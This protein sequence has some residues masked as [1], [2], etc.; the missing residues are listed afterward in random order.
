MLPNRREGVLKESGLRLRQGLHLWEDLRFGFRQLVRNPG[1]STVLVLTLAVGVGVNAAILSA[2]YAVV[3]QALPFK[4]PSS[5]VALFRNSPS[6]PPGFRFWGISTSDANVIRARSRTLSQIVIYDEEYKIASSD[7]VAQRLQ[8][9]LVDSDFFSFLGVRPR[10]G[11]PFVRSDTQGSG[12]STVVIGYRLWRDAFGSDPSA[13]GRT[14]LLD[15]KRYT[16]IGIMPATFDFPDG[17]Q[18]WLP[19]PVTQFPEWDP[20]YEAVARLVPRTSVTGSEAELE[21]ITVRTPAIRGGG[22]EYNFGVVELKDKLVPR[23]YREPLLILLGAAAFV[24]LIACVNVATLSLS[25]WFVRRPEFLIRRT[26]GATRWR[27][28]RQLIAESLVLACAGGIFSLIFGYWGIA[29]LRAGLPSDTP[30]VTEVH[31]G[32]SFI[33]FTLL[34]S[35]A[36]GLLAGVLPAILLTR[37]DGG[38]RWGGTRENVQAG[39]R[40]GRNQRARDALVT[41][42]VGM[43]LVLIAGAALALGGLRRILGISLGLKSDHVLTMLVHF[44][45]RRFKQPGE[46]AQF[47]RGMLEAVGPMQGLSGIAVA[48]HVPMVGGGNRTRFEIEGSLP[49]NDARQR[50]VDKNWVT[51][52]FFSVLRVPLLAGRDFNEQDRMTTSPVAIVSESFAKDYLGGH[53]AIGKSIAVDTVPGRAVVWRQVVGEVGDIR[54]TDPE[55]VPVPTVYLSLYQTPINFS[56]VGLLLRSAGEPRALIGPVRSRIAGLDAGG[57][58]TDIGTMG[59]WVRALDIGPQTRTGLLAIFGVLS[60]LLALLGVFG[61]V[62]YSVAQRS[63]EISI[64]MALGATPSHVVRLVIG[65]GMVV[66]GTGVFAGVLASLF[67]GRSIQALF[68]G[69]RPNSPLVLIFV[70]ALLIS[71]SLTACFVP[72]LRVARTEPMKELRHE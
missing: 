68:W 53:A 59:E 3:F 27:L 9:A 24:L 34:T 13:I 69:I 63:H 38:S 56:G 65:E 41:A 51:P 58:I 23:R 61:T 35:V 11:R 4:Q 71:A 8:A 49:G 29:L 1:F 36:A 40:A 72:A 12:D 16:I 55:V 30:R 22:K 45:P 31:A 32:G 21:A 33:L 17:S 20:E 44:P 42:E 39:S 57:V 19:L 18:L 48:V 7:G 64:R 5:L 67:L 60:F 70:A 6:L 47:T 43:A 37:T 10:Y 46:C 15:E 14:I 54:D 2:S 52:G 28:V 25:R 26:L 66:I 62:S 50:L